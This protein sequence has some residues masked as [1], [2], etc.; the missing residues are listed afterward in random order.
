MA[1]DSHRSVPGELP[2][3]PSGFQPYNKRTGDSI[4]KPPAKRFA[5]V[6]PMDRPQSKAQDIQGLDTGNLGEGF[7]PKR[8]YATPFG[9]DAAQ[10][11]QV[12]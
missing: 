10:S 7:V 11:T 5:V 4:I 3:R 6:N 9:S 8:P 1:L 2:K 12:V